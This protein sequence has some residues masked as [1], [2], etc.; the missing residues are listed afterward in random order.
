MQDSAY[1]IEVDQI[2]K[3]AWSDALLNFDDATIYQ[4]WSYGAIHWRESNLSHLVLKREGEVIGLA[5]LSIKK[6]PVVNLGIAYIPWGPLW[7]KRGNPKNYEDLKHLIQALKEEYVIR[8]RLLL[9]IAPNVVDDAQEEMRSLLQMEGFQ[10]NKSIPPYRTLMLDLSPS[11]QELRKGLDQKWR[12]QLNRAEKNGMTVIEGDSDELYHKFMNLQNETLDR[13]KYI[14]GV[15]YEEFREVQKELP[16]PLKMKIMLCE[17]EGEPITAAIGTSIGNTGIYLLGA[18]GDKGLQLKGA[19]LLQ[20]AMIQWFKE[21]NCRWYDLGG[22]NPDK[23]PGVFHFKAGLSGKDVYHIGQ[24]EACESLLSSC[25]VNWGERWRVNYSKMKL[26]FI[27]LRNR[28]FR[29]RL[30]LH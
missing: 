17:Y 30:F 11:L 23:N 18:S 27:E 8:R 10:L 22:I 15:D 16:E 13:K 20:W 12:N 1:T 25:I 28:S 4:T 9:R 7:Q 19:Y 14:P 29:N 6:I 2:E 26:A 3:S 24:F 5:Q 21:R